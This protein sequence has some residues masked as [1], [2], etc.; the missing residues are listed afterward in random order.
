MKSNIAVLTSLFH[1]VYTAV[2]ALLVY[3]KV[4]YAAHDSRNA[5]LSFQRTIKQRVTVREVENQSRTTS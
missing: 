5:V 2:R 3:T 4:G 1:V